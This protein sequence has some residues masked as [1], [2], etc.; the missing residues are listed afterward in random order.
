MT[1]TRF[2]TILE[3]VGTLVAVTVLGIAVWLDPDNRGFGTHEQLGLPPCGYLE[4]TGEL[5]V[6]CGM[7][8]SFAHM[9]EADPVPAWQANPVG[10]ALFLLTLAT[11]FWLIHALVTGKDPL[12][13]HAHRFGRFLLPALVISLMILWYIRS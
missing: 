2:W 3:I 13:F 11:P 6:S 8:T 7:T 12:R 10:V 1:G 9:A 4:T 5:C